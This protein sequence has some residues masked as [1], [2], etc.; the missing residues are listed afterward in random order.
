MGSTKVF[1]PATAILPQGCAFSVERIEDE[2]IGLLD[3]RFVSEM[4]EAVTI[5]LDLE[6]REEDALAES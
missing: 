6:P 1:E 3:I 4:E 2:V 5:T